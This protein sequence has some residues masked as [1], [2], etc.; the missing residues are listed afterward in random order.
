VL[1]FFEGDSRGTWEE[2]QR[3]ENEEVDF[4][5]K[6]LVVSNNFIVTSAEVNKEGT[7]FIYSRSNSGKWEQ[8]QQENVTDH[9]PRFQGWTFFYSPSVSISNDTLAVGSYFDSN[10]K[11]ER[12]G[13]VH[14]FTRGDG[15]TWEK[16]QKLMA[17]DGRVSDWFG[18]SLAITDNILV[19]GSEKDD[20]SG[21][22]KA[23]AVYLFA[24][25]GDG[26]WLE[27]KKVVAEDGAGSDFFGFSV[28]V[29]WTTVAIGAP[30]KNNWKGSV[31]FTDLND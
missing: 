15:G 30:L 11:N 19:V 10:D 31:Y 17:S 26:D 23:G 25:A 13:A 5:G 29:S 21:G 28:S 7:I 3:M 2:V 27:I 22:E 24:R 12:T 4:C 14:I 18:H 20:N 6:K 1:Y 8:I 16:T 9:T